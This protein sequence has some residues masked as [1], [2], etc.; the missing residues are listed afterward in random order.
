MSIISIIN[1]ATPCKFAD[2]EKVYTDTE[3]IVTF[4]HNKTKYY[5][6]NF[7][8]DTFE[9]KIITN[10]KLIKSWANYLK[11]NFDDSVLYKF[12]VKEYGCITTHYFRY[13]IEINK[14]EVNDIGLLSMNIFRELPIGSFNSKLLFVTSLTSQF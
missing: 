3:D 7:L 8:N 6:E 9:C 1:G 11:T 14:N 12:K 10:K 2:V 13:V 5:I 4:K